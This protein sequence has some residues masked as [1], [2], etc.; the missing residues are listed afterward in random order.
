MPSIIEEMPRKAIRTI[1]KVFQ[2]CRRKLQKYYL[3]VQIEE[4]QKHWNNFIA[5]TASFLV[6]VVKDNIQ[7]DQF[8][9]I[10]V[11]VY[12]KQELVQVN[13]RKS[14]Q[15]VNVADEKVP[16]CLIDTDGSREFKARCSVF[17]FSIFGE[18]D[19]EALLKINE[20]WI[21]YLRNNTQHSLDGI[22]DTYKKDGLRYLVFIIFHESD[23]H[24][25]KGALF[26]LKNSSI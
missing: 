5:Q 22:A 2:L 10:L 9:S 3:R 23:A 1:G 7:V 24:T 11:P 4:R 25:V 13:G 26:K 15:S 18:V 17:R 20:K 8:A 14:I 19:S 6:D 16:Q 21:Y 12:E